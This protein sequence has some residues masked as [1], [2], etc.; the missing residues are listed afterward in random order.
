MATLSAATTLLDL[1]F[2]VQDRRRKGFF[3]LDNE[4]LDR[5]GADLGPYGLAVY[6]AL[7][8]FANREG[9]CWPSFTTIAQRTGMSRRQVIR[10][11]A[12]LAAR[13]LIA[14]EAK[15]DQATGE[16]KANLYILLDVTGGD[17]Q[18]LG[19]DSQ[20]LGGGDSQSLG[21]DT[22]A[23]EQNKKKNTHTQLDPKKNGRPHA[24]TAAQ[25]PMA[26]K[27]QDVVVALTALG[28]AEDVASRLV[29][30]YSREHVLE[31][32]TYLEFLQ[33]EQPETV[34]RPCG[35]LR[36]AIE[37][38]YGRPDGFTTPAEQ[39]LQRAAVERQAQEEVQQER[40]HAEAR[41]A[42]QEEKKREE[43]ARWQA[44]AAQYGTTQREVDL[45]QQV[46]ADLRMQLPAATFEA[47]IVGT[48]LLCLQDEQAVV[49]LVQSRGKDWVENRLARTIQKLL[50]RYLAGKRVAVQFVTLA[51][52]TATAAGSTDEPGEHRENRP[53][54]GAGSPDTVRTT[55]GISQIRGPHAAGSLPMLYS[56]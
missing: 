43:Q 37:Q 48:Q 25:K 29:K 41:W 28:M 13:G 15:T 49:G 35:W 24:R 26:E 12:K 32:I 34:Q 23:P 14:V 18:S 7:A 30:R 9:E 54:T 10:E 5:F 52:A 38:N 4:L 46:L 56:T 19:S 21:S 27:D 2:T 53:V 40:L 31:K 33:A 42:F 1:P 8:R 6:V 55:N 51:G 20:A 17:S 45:W 47:F 11:T 3:T 44:L 36:S 16:H 39:A 50:T 22:E